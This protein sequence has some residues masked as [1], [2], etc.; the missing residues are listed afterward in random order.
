MRWRV[1]VV[2]IRGWMEILSGCGVSPDLSV[3]LMR[4]SARVRSG[5]L[6]V[7]DLG[8]SAPT[9][10]AHRPK[11]ITYPRPPSVGSEAGQLLEIG[12]LSS[13][14]SLFRL[15]ILN[16]QGVPRG[17][18]LVPPEQCPAADGWSYYPNS[19]R[20]RAASYTTKSITV[21]NMAGR[22]R[23]PIDEKALNRYLGDHVPEVKTPV[24]LKQVR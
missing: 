1:S 3:A 13:H 18:L 4:Y 14:A 12:S 20:F 17:I 16:S 22:V 8:W 23:Q 15:L 2:E 19:G 6:V 10:A 7:G 24:E 11:G 9:G 5:Y 21:I